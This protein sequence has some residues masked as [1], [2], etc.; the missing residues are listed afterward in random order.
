MEKLVILKKLVTYV[1][2]ANDL[3]VVSDGEDVS[4]KEEVIN[5]EISDGEDVSDVK[6]VSI[7]C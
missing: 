5:I 4:Y 7:E 6:Y 1:E 2:D 3:E